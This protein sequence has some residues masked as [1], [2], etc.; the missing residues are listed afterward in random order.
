MPL[1]WLKT[2][3][4]QDRNISQTSLLGLEYSPSVSEQTSQI[5]GHSF[6]HQYLLSTRLLHLGE[7]TAMN[8][9]LTEDMLP[10]T[11]SPKV[12][13]GLVNS[14]K[15]L[16]QFILDSSTHSVLIIRT[17][18]PTQSIFIQVSNT[19]N[20]NIHNMLNTTPQGKA[21]E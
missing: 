19:S 5:P 16:F 11:I 18:K 10:Q 1:L 3:I 2:V 17:M 9:V 14:E 15:L 12:L 20:E 7:K 6:V 13:L 21:N 8:T 4:T